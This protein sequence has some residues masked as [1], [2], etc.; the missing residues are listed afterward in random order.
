MWEWLIDLMEATLHQM[1]DDIYRLELWVKRIFH[2]N[3]R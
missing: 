2:I 1:S 3:Q